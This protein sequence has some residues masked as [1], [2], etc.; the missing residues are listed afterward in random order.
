[1]GKH[2][3]TNPTADHRARIGG[4]RTGRL[5][6]SLVAAAEAVIAADAVRLVERDEAPDLQRAIDRAQ[7]ATDIAWP[8][9]GVDQ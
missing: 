6:R 4:M 8:P 9:P 3:E 5:A 1:M 2:S 7:H